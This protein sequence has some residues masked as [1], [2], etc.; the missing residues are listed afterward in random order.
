M[1]E[2]V[3]I[4][5]DDAA[6]LLLICDVLSDAGIGVRTAQSG[7]EA[8]RILEKER[9]DLIVLDIMMK[10]ISGLEVCRRIRG[11]VDCPILFLSAKSDVRDVVRG[12][13]LGAD[14]YLT[15]PFVLEELVARI[16]AHLRRQARTASGGE[17]RERVLEIGAIR[18]DP[19]KMEVTRDGLP[20]A[21]S[22]KEFELLSYLMHNAGRT[23]SKEQIFRDVWKTGY[24][25]I[26]TVAI[27]IKNLRAKLDPDWS[28]IKTVWGSG[29]RFVTCSGYE[30]EKM[31][32]NEP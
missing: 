27:H 30:E 3:L 7:E 19:E 18:L 2:R 20:V 26:G 11:Q 9:F 21:L 15:K 14:D 6:I 5:D 31:E 1:S 12:L 24:G 17:R 16:Q 22:S 25:D 28:Y 10:G 23:L 32:G 8:I 4:V 13:G 29:Y